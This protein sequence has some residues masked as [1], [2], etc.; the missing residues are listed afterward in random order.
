[1]IK[2]NLIYLIQKIYLRLTLIIIGNPELRI[3]EDYLRILR[4]L[5]FF[6]NYSKQPHN[7]DIFRK[8][9]IN[10]E[11]VSKLSKERLLD[12]LKKIIKIGENQ[13][14]VKFVSP[15]NFNRE[16]VPQAMLGGGIQGV[17][18]YR[19]RNVPKTYLDM[20]QM[21]AVIGRVI[22]LDV[23]N[24]LYG[25]DAVDEWLQFGE[26]MMLL[27]VRSDQWRLSNNT[28]RQTVLED[29]DA[30]HLTQLHITAAESIERL[31]GEEIGAV[32]LAY[33][34]AEAGN[35]PKEAHY[36]A[37]AAKTSFHVMLDVTPCGSP[38]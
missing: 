5:R 38:A 35:L 7:L 21:A 1:M 15:L 26:E 12:E 20:L 30:A 18:R 22:N 23:M 9:K 28:I 2:K 25:N 24:D 29:I 19:L 4:Y 32:R 6:L 37:I 10:I 3:K 33:H 17:I 16:K 31:Y 8:L 13:L 36:K 14:E 34:W 27:R 11:G